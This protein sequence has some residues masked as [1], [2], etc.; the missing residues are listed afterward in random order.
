LP[1]GEGPRRKT[2]AVIAVTALGAALLVPATYAV[3]RTFDVLVLPPEPNPA[4]IV[5]SAHIAMFWR[6]NIAA[7]VASMATPLLYMAADANL[8]RTAR[9]LSVSVLPVTAMIALQGFLLP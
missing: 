3:L 4:T 9:V 5:W 1:A 7:Y 6:L 8:A 2:S